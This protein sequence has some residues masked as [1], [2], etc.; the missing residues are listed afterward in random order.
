MITRPQSLTHRPRRFRQCSA[1][2]SDRKEALVDAA[3][4]KSNARAGVVLRSRID[5]AALQRAASVF[6]THFLLD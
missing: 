3:I 6:I 2:V 5:L 1:G 4:A